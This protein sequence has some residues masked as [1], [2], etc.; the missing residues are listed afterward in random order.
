MKKITL[1]LATLLATA[2]GQKLDPAA[3]KSA[4]PRSEALHI[5]APNPSDSA[6]PQLAALARTVTGANL[7]LAPASTAA[8]APFAVTSYAFAMAV[9]TGV[10]WA[11]APIA[12]LTEVVPPTACTDTACTWGPGAGAGELNRWQLVVTRAGD[13]YDYVLSGQPV[14]SPAAPFV[15]VISGRAYPGAIAHRGHGS[16]GVDFDQ[17]WSGLAHATGETQHDFGSIAVDYDARGEAIVNATFRDA[18]NNDHP[19]DP[20]AP[21]KVSAAY[22]FQASATGGD[23]QLGF[24]TQPPYLAG[25]KDEQVTLR[26]QWNGLGEGRADVNYT[27]PGFSAGFNQCW[28]GAPDY[29]MTFDGDP[30]APF[31]TI[32]ACKFAAAPITI[33]VP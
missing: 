26:T 13:G 32:D 28:D 18:I 2:C 25:Y 16:F 33:T 21:N 20:S 12:W 27:T 4:M 24:H 30:G 9:N 29:A 7:A 3:V 10:F 1:L 14:A 11:L 8:K 5:G 19:G 17:A 6:P 15:P 22:A 31:G 23:L